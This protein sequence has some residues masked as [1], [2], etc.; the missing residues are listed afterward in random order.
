MKSCQRE[1]NIE[2]SKEDFIENQYLRGGISG[3]GGGRM[4]YFAFV[5]LGGKGNLL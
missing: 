5:Y 4:Q 1:D 3:K 2:K